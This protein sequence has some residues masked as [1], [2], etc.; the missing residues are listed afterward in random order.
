MN[1]CTEL[2][3]FWTFSIVGVFESRNTTFQKLD[4]FPFSDEGGGRITGPVIEI[5]SF[6][7]GP[8]E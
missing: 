7:G 8:T 2:M 4:L 3:G 1:Y 6:Q 5:S